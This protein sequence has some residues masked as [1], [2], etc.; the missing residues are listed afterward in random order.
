MSSKIPAEKFYDKFADTYDDVLKDSKCNAQHVNEAVKIFHR[1]N[2]HQGNILDIGCGTGILSQLLQGDFEYTGIDI[3]SKMLKYAAQRGYETIHKPI[4][5]ALAEIDTQSYDFVFCLSSLL[6]VQ[7]A[8][9][10]IQHIRRI[11]RKT[12]LISLDETT[13]EYIKNFVVPVFDH[14]KI[15]LEDPLE[16]YFIVG[17]TSPT[18]GI[19]IRTRMIYIEQKS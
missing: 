19:S 16:D 10:A 11:A 6:F 14:S 18:L 15:A 9:A 8:T 12:I 7:D 3:S 17:W 5:V 1:H 4:E 2:H 13:E